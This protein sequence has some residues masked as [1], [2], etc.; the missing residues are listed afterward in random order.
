[1]CLLDL[2]GYLCYRSL[3]PAASDQ[4]YPK[5]DIL[6]PDPRP[7][8]YTLLQAI[9]F[10]LSLLHHEPIPQSKSRGSQDS[11]S[12]PAFAARL[13]NTFPVQS[14]SNIGSPSKPPV[15]VPESPSKRA[16]LSIANVANIF[17]KMRRASDQVKPWRIESSSGEDPQSHPGVEEAVTSTA[18]EPLWR[19][20]VFI[21]DGAVNGA[22]LLRVV[23]NT[24]MEL[25]EL[26]GANALVDERWNCTILGPKHRP[27]GTF[28]VQ[29]TLKGYSQISYTASATR[30]DRADPHRPV[31]LDKVKGVPGLMTVIKRLNE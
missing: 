12:V 5:R 29:Q 27:N 7:A 1:M 30:S 9:Q 4:D 23:R 11:P 3:S 18:R 15:P 20:D 2:T 25:A 22:Q 26:I 14:G 16:P 6:N 28:K 10:S 8:K 24:L 21:C 19:T 17:I 31:A 13:Q